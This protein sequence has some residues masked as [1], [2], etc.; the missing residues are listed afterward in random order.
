MTGLTAEEI[1]SSASLKQSEEVAEFMTISNQ[2]KSLA[3]FLE[4]NSNHF[5]P[6]ALGV[7]S[8]YLQTLI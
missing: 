7:L 5:S 2:K 6:S 1:I 3:Q 4:A 8:L